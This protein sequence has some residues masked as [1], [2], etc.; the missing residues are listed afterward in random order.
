TVS[1]AC[2]LSHSVTSDGIR[3]VIRGRTQALANVTR[4]VVKWGW[5]GAELS[6]IVMQ[7]LAPYSRDGDGRAHIEGP[8]L[9]LEPDTAQAIAITLHELTTNAT[10]YG[11]LSVSDGHIR[12]EWSETQSGGGALRWTETKG[13]AVKPSTHK[14]FGRRV[15]ESMVGNHLKG[16]VRFIWSEQGLACEIA[17]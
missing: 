11:A 4:L 12:V 15:I 14:G 8:P 16:Q 2:H 10:K 5:I 9:L 17:W 13:P 6:N 1:A 3:R 7:E